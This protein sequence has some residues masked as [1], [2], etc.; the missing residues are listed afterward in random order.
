MR[1]HFGIVFAATLCSCSTP[2]S[3][4]A[5]DRELSSALLGVWCNS[6]DGGRTCW[7]FDEFDRSGHFQACGKHDDE[8][9]GFSGG[10]KFSV[11]GQRMCY[12]VDNAT[13]NF[14]LGVGG[15]YCTDILSIGQERHRYRDIDSQQE[16]ELIRVPLSRKLCPATR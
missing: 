10:G 6:D 2:Q 12:V 15:I 14:W 1:A 4:P 16:F 11:I 9:L 8:A 7:A 3:V 5:L 13:P